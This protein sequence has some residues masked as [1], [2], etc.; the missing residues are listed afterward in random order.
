MSDHPIRTEGLT[1]VYDGVKAVDALDLTVNKGHV[2]NRINMEN[3][4]Q[5]EMLQNEA[6]N[7]SNAYW[8]KQQDLTGMINLLSPVGSYQD[9]SFAIMSDQKPVDLTAMSTNGIWKQTKINFWESLSLKWGNLVA[10]VLM[11]IA[12]FAVSYVAFMRTDIR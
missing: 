7:T 5:S 11:A 10:L 9:L 12:S 6:R 1:K 4:K 3:Q 8:K 2:A